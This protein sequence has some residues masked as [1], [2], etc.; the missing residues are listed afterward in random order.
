MNSQ[1]I[2]GF[3]GTI[4]ALAA[5]AAA[6]YYVPPGG[7]NAPAKQAEPAESQPAAANPMPPAKPGPVIRDIPQQ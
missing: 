7:K 3:L 4:V 1:K 6:F 5:L 2:A